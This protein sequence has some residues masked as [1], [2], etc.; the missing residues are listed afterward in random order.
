MLTCASI[1]PISTNAVEPLILFTRA[2]TARHIL[3]PFFH[4]GRPHCMTYDRLAK[5]NS[6]VIAWDL[7]MPETF[8]A[9][10]YQETGGKTGEE[11]VLEATAAEDNIGNVRQI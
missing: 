6:A 9:P 11:P 8:E 7:M 5:G 10:F 4:S 1:P 3:S 2:G